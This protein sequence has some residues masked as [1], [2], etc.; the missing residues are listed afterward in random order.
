MKIFAAFLQ[1]K[2]LL[3]KLLIYLQIGEKAKKHDKARYN[4]KNNKCLRKAKNITS[5]IL[6]LRGYKIFSFSF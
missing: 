3:I 6:S 2:L 1:C 4:V 5:L